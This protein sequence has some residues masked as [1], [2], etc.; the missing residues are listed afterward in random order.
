MRCLRGIMTVLFYGSVLEYTNEDKSIEFADCSN[1][2]ELINKL[3]SRYGERFKNFL[4]G[5][6]TCFF[7]INGT[8][9]MMTGGLETGLQHGDKIEVLPFVGAG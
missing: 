2:R 7:L 1:V 6:E 8:G 3:G 4:L 5:E 9:L